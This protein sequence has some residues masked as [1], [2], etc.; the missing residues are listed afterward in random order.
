VLLGHPVPTTH[1][2]SQCEPGVR[3][4]VVVLVDGTV[5]EVDGTGCGREGDFAVFPLAS[6]KEPVG[7]PISLSQARYQ[8]F[9]RCERTTGFEPATLTLAR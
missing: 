4:L 7:N 5:V 2:H 1:R 3:G 6:H 8:H 9:L